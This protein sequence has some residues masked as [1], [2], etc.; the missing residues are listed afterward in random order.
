MPDPSP[1]EK[2]DLDELVDLLGP[3]A[4]AETPVVDQAPPVRGSETTGPTTPGPQ[5]PANHGRP[6]RESPTAA[7][8]PEYRGRFGPVQ[9]RGWGRFAATEVLGR[10]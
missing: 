5:R 1:R 6:R 7:T 3:S 9:R 2:N 8:P 4:S 10:P